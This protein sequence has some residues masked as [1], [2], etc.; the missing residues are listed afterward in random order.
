LEVRRFTVLNFY[1]GGQGSKA[2]RQKKKESSVIEIFKDSKDWKGILSG[3]K[4][5]EGKN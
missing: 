2:H 5:V 4:I 3:V 1:H